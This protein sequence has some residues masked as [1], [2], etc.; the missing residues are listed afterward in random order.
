[1]KLIHVPI[2]V[3]FRS[4][5][6]CWMHSMLR[7]DLHLSTT[8]YAHHYTPSRTARIRSNHRASLC[9]ARPLSSCS[10]SFLFPRSVSGQDHGDILHGPLFDRLTR[11]AF[12]RAQPHTSEARRLVPLFQGGPPCVIFLVRGS[13]GLASCRV[14]T[15][16]PVP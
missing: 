4:T 9:L 13:R 10:V 11:A 14:A 16:R 8:V 12:F 15:P 2:I 1:L 5:R 6:S 3:C 7:S